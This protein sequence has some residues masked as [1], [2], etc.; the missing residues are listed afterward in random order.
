MRE[1]PWWPL[2]RCRP[3]VVAVLK[4]R[5]HK[6]EFKDCQSEQ[7]GLAFVEKDRDAT[8]VAISK[9]LTGCEF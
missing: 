4:R 3:R 5:K 1:E 9:G 6:M 2:L 8:Q 7:K